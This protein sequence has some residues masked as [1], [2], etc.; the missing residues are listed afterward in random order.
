MEILNKQPPI[1][2]AK[3]KRHHYIPKF[4]LNGFVDPNNKPYIW[5]Y[6]K[7]KPQ[8]IEA[9]PRD[10]AVQKNYY[11]IPTPEG[12]DSESFENFLANIERHVAPIFRKI[13]AQSNLTENDRWWFAILL[14][15]IMTRVPN[16]RENI[17]KACAEVIKKY[18]MIS[19]SNA[20]AF[21]A[22]VASFEQETGQKIDMPKEEF[23]KFMLEGNYNIEVYP[24]FSLRM[25]TMGVKDLSPIFYGMKWT[26]IKATEDYKFVTSDNPLHLHNP[27]PGPPPFSGVGLCHKNIQVTFPISKDFA[28]LGT[29]KGV[30]RYVKVNNNCVK[31]I[32][33]TTIISASRFVFASLKSEGVNRLAQKCKNTA[34]RLVVR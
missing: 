27:T 19:A 20:R 33:R 4:Y 1:G 14:T 8:V 21:E 23:R 13:E 15:L 24:H 6:E 9:I 32:N 3:K 29:W 34:P 2:S 17:E 12:K 25:V 10:V 16:F 22:S 31:E 30:E 18:A 11:T 5:V 26:F 28:F 7:G